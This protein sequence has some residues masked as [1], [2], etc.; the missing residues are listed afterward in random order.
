MSTPYSPHGKD[1]KAFPYMNFSGVDV[2]TPAIAM[3]NPESQPL[4]LMNNCHADWR[5]IINLDAPYKKAS[6]NQ[7]NVFHVKH[8]SSELF[9][10]THRGESDTEIYSSRGHFKAAVFKKNAVVSSVVFNGR[11]LF[12]SAGS[13]IITYDGAIFRENLGSH[14]SPAYVTAIQRR[15][16]VAG[17]QNNKTTIWTSRVD[18]HEIFPDD[19]EDKEVSVL[20]AASLDL[21]NII[22]TGDEI[23]GMQ[24][25]DGL[26]LAIFTNDK[27]FIYITNP[28]YT[29]WTIDQSASVHV[30]TLSNNSIVKANGDLIFCS[31]SGVHTIRRA[32]QNGIVTYS[33]PMSMKVRNLYQRL[34]RLMKNREDI[35]ATYDSDEGQY[36]VFFPVSQKRVFRLTATIPPETQ[37]LDIN[38]VKWSSADFLS[39]QCGDFFNG[40]M[41]IGTP[42]GVYEKVPVDS[43]GV[44]R[45]DMEFVTPYLWMNDGTTVKE[46]V[47]FTLQAE[48]KG[49]LEIVAKNEIGIEIGHL[50]IP[51]EDEVTDG[52]FDFP[53]IRQQSRKFE[54]RFKGLQFVFKSRSEGHIKVVGFA[55][56][57]RKQ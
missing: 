26:R 23:K 3:E 38:S 34:V 13:P 24:A 50:V 37:Q 51:L 19:E 17:M 52:I 40:E 1:I 36:H 49:D 4:I 44:S 2:S 39:A 7:R 41:L 28:D 22:D 48:G 32:I 55:I 42:N 46:S 8:V 11:T 47:S 30:G 27:T 53:L 9:C 12:A 15:L 43:I 25:I 5:G 35:S 33:V 57:V 6:D 21:R 45:P 16:V 10:Y 18:Q 31:R 14:G 29:K 56:N 54:Y 20:R